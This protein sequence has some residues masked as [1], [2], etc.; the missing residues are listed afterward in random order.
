MASEVTKSMLDSKTPSSVN[1]RVQAREPVTDPTLGIAVP[2]AVA[3][4]PRHRLVTIGDSLTHGF[5][6]AAI[7]NTDISYPMIMAWE[8]GWD[9][10]F[11]RPHYLGHGGLPL[12]IEFVIRQLERDYGDKLN[13]WELPLAVFEVRHQLAEIDDWWERGPGAVVPNE[14]GIKHNLAI[15]GWDLRDTLSR[16]F[17]TESRAIQQPKEGGLLPLIQNANERA[18]LRVLASARD[19]SGKALTPLGAASALG[20]E[21]SKEDGTGDGI[22]T[23]LVFL[24]ANN[25][26][27]SVVNLKVSWS[28]APEYKDLDQ[29]TAFTV[30]A[31]D[32]FAAELK[33]VV[34]Q[35]KNIR[36]RHVIWGTVPHVTIPPIT[37]GVAGKVRLGS[38]YFPYY[39]RPWIADAD[40]D[41]SD[42]PC[43]TGQEARA[44]DSA[45]DQYND[46]IV[47]AVRTARQQGRD[48]YVLD[49]AGLLDRLASRRYELD[50]AARPQWWTKYELPPALQQLSPKPDSQFFRSGPQG[51]TAGGLFSLDGVHPTTIAYGL[52]AQEFINIMQRAGV[53][54]YMGDGETE[55]KGPIA[56]DFQRLIALDTLISDPPRSLTDDL[57]L[58]G[59][60]D[61][62][63]DF[64]T[65]M[66]RAGR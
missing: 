44:V 57:S 24:G 66:F 54:F 52:I 56:V 25:A 15:Y 19:S 30:W 7:Y 48:W 45:I 2:T 33:E 42:D 9:E 8:M 62:K 6:S 21:G 14:V 65:R 58:I 60:V 11:R 35:V 4:N 32:H 61:E 27:Q 17:D 51:R 1:I 5:Q 10:H 46:A 26:L 50:L 39:T 53:K 41:P 64:L 12:N 43:I 3:G 38:R 40:F 36:A 18:A 16:D 20:A 23:L 49:V 47:D 22:E 29:K 37:H 59:W 28:T 31:P 13:W 34:A 63:M 55:R